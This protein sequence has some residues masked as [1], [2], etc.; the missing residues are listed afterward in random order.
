[1]TSYIDPNVMRLGP[2]PP[3]L[4]RVRRAAEDAAA[5]REKTPA[6]VRD[7]DSGFLVLIHID[8]LCG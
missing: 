5:A 4:D 1:V 6:R 3:N 2:T 7:D 8:S